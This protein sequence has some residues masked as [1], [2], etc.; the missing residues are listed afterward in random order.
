MVV[1][2]LLFWLAGVG[3]GWAQPR[4]IASWDFDQG[5]G[6]VLRDTSGNGHDGAI[7]GAT[8]STGRFGGGLHFDGQD[9]DVEVPAGPAF[10][11]EDALSLEVWA[12]LE[13]LGQVKDRVVIAR[14]DHPLAYGGWGLNWGYG[15]DFWW[16][17]DGDYR[18]MAKLAQG[19]WVHLVL[20]TSLRGYSVTLYVN[21]KLENRSLWG[22]PRVASSFPLL[23]GRRGQG[24]HFSGWLDGITLYDGAL[25]P[26]QVAARFRGEALPV[27]S[28]PLPAQ[29]RRPLP[30]GA[31]ALPP[32]SVEFI[33]A[34]GPPPANAP[35]V[36]HNLSL[37][38]ANRGTAPLQ[39]TDTWLDGCQAKGTD[40]LFAGA[41][42]EFVFAGTVPTVIPAGGV[43]ILNLK[44]LRGAPLPE[45]IAVVLQE[46]GGRVVETKASFAPGAA[47]FESIA[48]D[49]GL[50]GAWVYLRGNREGTLRRITLNGGGGVDW[51]ARAIRL[52]PGELLPV[53]LALSQPLQPGTPI[54][55]SAH[56]DDGACH[57]FLYAF[58][59]RFPVGMYRVQRQ[60]VGAD[61]TP[62]AG[63]E[64]LREYVDTFAV[65]GKT[66]GQA[67]DEWLADC[68]RH[69]IDTL[70]P[71]YVNCGG[72]PTIAA[73]FG[74]AVVPYAR[75]LDRYANHPAIGAWYFAD[76]PGRE[77]VAE[78]LARLELIRAADRTRP[79]VVTI[80]P[81]VW[82]RG[83]DYD[84][85]DVGYQDTYP[86][87][88]QPLDTIAA[89][90]ALYARLLA[91]KPVC[92]I[93][94]CFRIAPNL[95]AG[96]CRFPTPA[97]ERFMVLM[98]LA[99]GARGEIYFAYNVEPSEPVE[100][101]GVSTAPEA[102]ALWAEIG[103]INLELRTL[104][105]LLAQSCVID[106]RRTGAVEVARL[107]LGEDTIAAIILNHDY[108]YTQETFAP[109]PKADL[110]V[111]LTAPGWLTIKD[112]FALTPD[113]LLS[114][115]YAEGSIRLERLD[116][117]AIVVLTADPAL[118]GRLQARRA[119]LIEAAAK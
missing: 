24:H 42:T 50:R 52:A 91:P 25:T 100:G 40:V 41:T 26:E 5:S 87:P 60:T 8:W 85:V 28:T 113:G 109:H 117:G 63:R 93:P 72:D 18:H 62:P 37:A 73:R 64:W 43:G 97:E 98:S 21:G 118:R 83:V 11:V 74:F 49:E 79:I 17:Q 92:F 112:A 58:P 102:H 69:Y 45:T 108:E 2:T 6:D 48:F 116:A 104:A 34:W 71:D 65:A 13:D 57:A 81:P 78:V 95:T 75:H 20:V 53:Y 35:P 82:P 29:A 101:C 96:W 9:D 47:W 94:Q 1:W 16:G 61:Y 66:T 14:A 84:L 15:T 7:H 38:L 10:D 3:A 110:A 88:G 107:A 23:I 44:L 31:E 115:P 76:E 19:E 119:E 67:P 105:P 89:N 55:L 77:P 59:A 56:T 99:A 114:L 46:A 106:T 70:V 86:V 80:N 4:V 12:K 111:P 90:V 39:V 30:A 22:K 68:R 33:G 51:H 103:R 36:Y 54:V 27:A 32:G